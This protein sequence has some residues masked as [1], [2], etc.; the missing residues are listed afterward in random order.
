MDSFWSKMAWGVFTALVAGMVV[1]MTPVLHSYNPV[2]WVI[3]FGF[4]M[5][6]PFVVLRD[7]RRRR[8]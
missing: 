3:L 5:A 4:C 1:A 2:M 8:R 6:I 7:T